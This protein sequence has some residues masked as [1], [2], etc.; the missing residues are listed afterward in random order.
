MPLVWTLA[1][2]VVLAAVARKSTTPKKA[3]DDL[4]GLLVL[5]AGAAMVFVNVTI[6]LIV[7]ATAAVVVMIFAH[8]K[9]KEESP[10]PSLLSRINPW[11]KNLYGLTPEETRPTGEK[12]GG[13][14]EDGIKDVEK[15]GS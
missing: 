14:G 8:E 13:K 1:A 7:F 15:A 5:A 6:P 11:T 9:G 4:A 12:S 10:K 2:I 3:W